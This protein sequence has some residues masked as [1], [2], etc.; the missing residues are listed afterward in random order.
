MEAK[1][2]SEA[3][4][5]AQL[6]SGWRRSDSSAVPAGAPMHITAVTPHPRRRARVDIFVDGVVAGQISRHTAKKRSLRPGLEL[7]TEQLS[8]LLAEDQRHLALQAA[9]AMIAR[10]PRSECQVR[11]ALARRKLD[12][13]AISTAIDRLAEAHLLD[14]AAYAAHYAESRDRTSPRS[15]RLL[16]KELIAAG[17]AYETASVAVSE[18]SNE[19]AAYRVALS[20]SRSLERL[21][22]SAY[23]HRLAAYLQ[24]RGFSWEVI[25]ATVERCLRERESGQG[26]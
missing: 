24:R 25:R 11:S 9:V 23:R 14:D 18:I 19:D 3:R 20:R 16:R 1:K 8:E 2:P 10:R 5:S 15:Q 26:V 21:D 4:G 7:T 13:D 17:I 6:I 22:E 12:G